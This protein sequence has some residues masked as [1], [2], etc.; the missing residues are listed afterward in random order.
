MKYL[1]ANLR[2]RLDFRHKISI[3]T[4]PRANRSEMEI[5]SDKNGREITAQAKLRPG[6]QPSA[7]KM[8]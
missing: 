7:L 8:L 2:T 5:M 3:V 4:Y 1:R 6:R